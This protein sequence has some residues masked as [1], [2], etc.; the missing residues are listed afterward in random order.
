MY[1]NANLV[2]LL[3]LVVLSLYQTSLVCA[4]RKI[5][6]ILDENSECIMQLPW[7]IF[8][9]FPNTSTLLLLVLLSNSIPLFDWYVK[10]LT[11][12]LH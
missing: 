12:A 1:V 8:R 5:V 7:V 10:K 6:Y 4:N 3:V 11:H 9:I 2:S